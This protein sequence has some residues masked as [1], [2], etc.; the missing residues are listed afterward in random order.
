MEARAGATAQG[1][2]HLA[3]MWQTSILSLEFL[4]TARSAELGITPK[5]GQVCHPQKKQK[6][7]SKL[8]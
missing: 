7:K 5:H 4:S 2:Q 8:K 1:L 6:F 3:C